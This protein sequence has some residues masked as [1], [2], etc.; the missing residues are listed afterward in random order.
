MDVLREIN[1]AFE[2]IKKGK[3]KTAENIYLELLK[4]DEKNNIILSFLGLLYINWDKPKK[5]ETVLEKAYKINKSQTTIESLA[6]VKDRLNK[7][8]QALKYFEEI[9]DTTKNYDIL[10]KYI[11]LLLRLNKNSK[12]SEV[13]EKLVEL[14]PLKK[15]AHSRLIETYIN[16]GKLKEAYILAQKLTIKYPK[17]SGSWLW[18]GILREMLFQDD[19]GAEECFKKVLKFGDKYKGYYNLSVNAYKRGYYKKA[20]DYTNKYSRYEILPNSSL[21]GKA[22]ICMKTRR[23]KQGIRYYSDY[24]HLERFKDPT[25]EIYKLK[26]IWDG[27]RYKDETLFIYGDQGAGDLIMFSRYLPFVSKKFK[28][29]KVLIRENMMTLFNRSFKQYKNIEF[30]NPKKLKRLPNYDKSGIMACLPYYLKQDYNNIPFA[31]GY[32]VPNDKAVENYKSLMKTDKLKV[33]ICWEAGA[34]GWREQINRTLNVILYEPILKLKNAKIYSLQVNPALDNYKDYKEITDLGSG[35]K[36][37]D[38][39]T[40]ALMNLDVLVT[41][42][43]SLAHLAGALGVKTFMLLPYSTDWR[44]FDDTKDTNWYKSITIFK[45][46]IGEQWEDVISRV[47]AELERQ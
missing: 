21:F 18:W 42:D 46:N 12:A 39:T 15:E 37:Y 41:V 33:G 6:L 1:S 36:D 45:Q 31:D 4:T 28:R 8:K 43:T 44:W 34:A 11:K 27:K 16:A 13:A 32:M 47:V 14:F 5:A 22:N 38:D 30:Y 35:F 26:N 17:Y 24:I 2:Y 40:G 19:I 20:W 23:F 3:F 29:V 10:D 9:A 7:R 25:D